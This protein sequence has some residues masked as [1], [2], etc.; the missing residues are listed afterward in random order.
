MYF[1]ILTNE[2]SNERPHVHVGLGKGAGRAAMKVWIDIIEIAKLK[3]TW[4]S[5]KMKAALNVIEQNQDDLLAEWVKIHG[6][7]NPTRITLPHRA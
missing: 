6:S 3:G 7:T 1:R 2:P 5:R 4:P